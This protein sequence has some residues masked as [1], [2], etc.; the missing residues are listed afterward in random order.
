[1]VGAGG[2]EQPVH[3][4]YRATGSLFLRFSGFIGLLVAL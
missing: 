4:I 1:M 3:Y 2:F